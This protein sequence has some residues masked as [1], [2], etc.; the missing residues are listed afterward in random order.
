MSKSDSSSR[1]LCSRSK[2]TRNTPYFRD[3]YTRAHSRSRTHSHAYTHVTFNKTK[4]KKIIV[5]DVY[6]KLLNRSAKRR[7]ISESSPLGPICN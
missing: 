2:V 6:D 1:R 5:M 4:K 3:T 7:R